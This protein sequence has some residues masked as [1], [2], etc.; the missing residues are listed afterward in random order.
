MMVIINAG[1]RE[2]KKMG[3]KNFYKLGKTGQGE[4]RENKGTSTTPGFLF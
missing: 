4:L 3:P 1:V 2:I